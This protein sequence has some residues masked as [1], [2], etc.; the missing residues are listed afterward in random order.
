M[1]QI[2]TAA[3]PDFIAQLSD[4]LVVAKRGSAIEQ[5]DPAANKT[6]VFRASDAIVTI[7]Y[8]GIAYVGQI[9]TDRWIAEVL[10]QES[11][12]APDARF[13]VRMGGGRR[14]VDIGQ[15]LILL[16]RAIQELPAI[17]VDEHGLE[18]LVAGWQAWRDDCRPILVELSRYGGRTK[19]KRAPRHWPKDSN[20][21]IGVIGVPPKKGA[22]TQRLSKFRLKEEVG[23][24]TKRGPL[25]PGHVEGIFLNTLRETSEFSET[26][27]ANALSVVL[28]RPGHGIMGCRFYPIQPHHVKMRTAKGEIDVE[29]AMTP[30]VLGP[31]IIYSPSIE[32]GDSVLGLG[33]LDFHIFGAPANSGLTLSSSIKRPPPPR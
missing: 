4:R 29:V 13:G 23:Q 33:G 2:L 3:C 7:G 25:L 14:P 31:G 20:F 27:G 5:H 15:A 26:V 16:E 22:I 24:A 11:F 12:G 8:T 9:P 30:W 1:T 19:L 6:V 32:V 18:L 21:R 10:C 17:P 28:M